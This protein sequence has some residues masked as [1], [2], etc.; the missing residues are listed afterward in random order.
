[1]FEEVSLGQVL[2]TMTT[3]TKVRIIKGESGTETLYIGT[4]VDAFETSS[5]GLLAETV[6]SVKASGL[7][8]QIIRL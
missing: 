3:G 8:S 7:N 2:E 6:M 5:E 1:M 4:A